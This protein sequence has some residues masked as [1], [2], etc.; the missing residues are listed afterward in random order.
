M[1]LQLVNISKSFDDKEVLKDISFTFTSPNLYCILSPSGGGKSTLLSILG[2]LDS[3]DSGEVLFDDKKVNED[4]ESSFIGGH[5]SFTFQD[6]NLFENLSVFENLS[7]YEPDKEKIKE[8][9][10]QFKLDISLDSKV[11][12]LSGGER[13]RLSIIRSLL[14]GGDVFLF[15]EPS[16]NLDETNAYL[17]FDLIK[18]VSKTK[19]C[20]VVTH[21]TSLAYQYGDHILKLEDHKLID[22]GVGS[23]SLTL[24]IKNKGLAAFRGLYDIV[25]STSEDLTL[26]INN[27]EIKINSNNATQVIEQIYKGHKEE[28]LGIKFKK[29]EKTPIDSNSQYVQI[30]S[31]K[32]SKKPFFLSY[33]RKTI[34]SKGS[35]VALFSVL[36]S[37]FFICVSAFSN[38]VYSNDIGKT[39]AEILKENDYEYTPLEYVYSKGGYTDIGGSLI[40]NVDQ[41]N[42]YMFRYDSFLEYINTS[43]YSTALYIPIY[44]VSSDFVFQDEEYHINKGEIVLSETLKELYLNNIEFQYENG[45]FLFDPLYGGEDVKG[46]E[47]KYLEFYLN[48]FSFFDVYFPISSMTTNVY[49]NYAKDIYNAAYKNTLVAF[50]DKDYFFEAYYNY[51]LDNNINIALQTNIIEQLGNLGNTTI[52]R[53][54]QEEIILGRAPKEN[55]E[56]VL[57]YYNISTQLDPILS[58]A[59]PEDLLGLKIPIEDYSLSNESYQYNYFDIT[60]EIIIT[61][62][63]NEPYASA[64]YTNEAVYE[65]LVGEAFNW[66][67]PYL[68]VENCEN[69]LSRLISCRIYS[70]VDEL[71]SLVSYQ[72]EAR[73][74]FMWLWI[75]ILCVFIALVILISVLGGFYFIKDKYHDIA[76]L[77]SLAIKDSHIFIIFFL[78]IL[79]PVLIGLFVSLALVAPV[80]IGLNS[81]FCAIFSPR[82]ALSYSLFTIN[83]LSITLPILITIV[84]PSIVALC[85]VKRITSKKPFKSLKEYRK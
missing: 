50:I 19:L 61:G 68:L 76:V 60:D 2:L 82:A 15:D 27:E 25:S 70:S 66:F 71:S 62:I 3:P 85:F 9:L 55:N 53:Y 28:I 10:Y 78:S 35:R 74:D 83:W 80:T 30:T 56:I 4:E 33:F 51:C 45:Y 48:N 75:L 1:R 59:K 18:E 64:A 12:Y 63:V 69:E 77:K 8:I 34:F 11:K 44:L 72:I 52:N 16:G 40:K 57:N 17:V 84:V 20:I 32:T 47:D 49:G 81:M 38:L 65:Y 41:S 58:A 22:S 39:E 6:Y 46:N 54:N 24:D 13:Q 26:L 31:I 43:G 67:T 7:L 5:I 37:V 21:N 42:T 36:F 79:V 73:S 29:D 23:S 14:K